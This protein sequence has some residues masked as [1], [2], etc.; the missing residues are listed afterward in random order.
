MQEEFQQECV[1]V[2][3]TIFSQ[4]KFRSMKTMRFVDIFLTVSAPTVTQN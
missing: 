2:V 1:R 3:D 4:Y